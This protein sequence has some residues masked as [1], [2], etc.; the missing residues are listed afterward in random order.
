MSKFFSLSFGHLC[1]FRDLIF[2]KSYCFYRANKSDEALKT[3]DGYA[4]EPNFFV[5]EL[6]AQILYRLERYMDAVATYQEIIKNV[7]DEYEDERYTNL[8]AAMVY[9]D[10]INE[11]VIFTQINLYL[12]LKL[13]HEY[14]LN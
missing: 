1:C 4:G 8:S 5:K 7:D 10:H 12:P 2:E 6:K 13:I 11:N 9:L 3:I 14:I